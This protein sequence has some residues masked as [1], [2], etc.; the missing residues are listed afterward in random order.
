[1][2]SCRLSEKTIKK[3]K[4]KRIRSGKSWNL[5]FSR[6]NTKTMNKK[7]NNRMEFLLTYFKQEKDHY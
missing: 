1:M 6:F 3:L 7:I 4:E 5:F 2:F